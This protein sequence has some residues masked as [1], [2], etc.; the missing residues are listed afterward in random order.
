[1][2]PYKPVN[3]DVYTQKEYQKMRDRVL[4][5]DLEQEDFK[6]ESVQ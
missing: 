1:M 3:N 4:D 2:K 6:G 5:I